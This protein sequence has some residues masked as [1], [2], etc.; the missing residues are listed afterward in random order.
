MQH[1]LRIIAHYAYL[2][3]LQRP[4]TVVIDLDYLI[5]VYDMSSLIN[6]SY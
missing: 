4:S 3:Q 2:G 1:Q 5:L 6:D